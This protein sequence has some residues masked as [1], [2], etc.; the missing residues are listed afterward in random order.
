VSR[1]S[2]WGAG[3]FL[4]AFP[5]ETTCP[6][7][8]L[9]LSPPNRSQDLG[10]W[11]HRTRTKPVRPGCRRSAFGTSSVCWGSFSPLCENGSPP[12]AE[13]G[14]RP[15]RGCIPRRA[16]AITKV[17]GPDVAAPVPFPGLVQRPAVGA[18]RVRSL[19]S[20]TKPRSVQDQFSWNPGW[21]TPVISK[22]D[23]RSDSEFKPRRACSKH[24]AGT[25]TPRPVP[26]GLHLLGC[27]G[28]IPAT[29][30]HACQSRPIWIQV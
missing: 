29:V 25:P 24:D 13:F 9:T 7:P 21:R 6:V 5:G 20:A 3:R 26:P 11:A 16:A 18:Q 10:P 22:R 15:R 4:R 12:P 1:S 17:S 27:S 23:C 30:S 28:L 19:H 14:F 8:P 2:G